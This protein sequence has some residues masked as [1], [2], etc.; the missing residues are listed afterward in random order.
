MHIL[1]K[2]NVSEKYIKQARKRNKRTII[3][4]KLEI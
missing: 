3:Q 1:V 4:N 2:N